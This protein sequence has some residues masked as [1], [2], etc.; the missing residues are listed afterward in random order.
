MKPLSQTQIKDRGFLKSF[1]GT[2]IYYELR[3][4]GEPVIFTYGIACMLNDFIYQARHLSQ[5]YQTCLYDLRGHHYSA[6]P[7]KRSNLSLVALAKDVKAL[8]D[9]MGGKKVHL[10]SHCFGSHVA[11]KT[12][13][14]YPEI[15]KTM[16]FF[17]GYSKNII[18]NMFHSR[19]M[20]IVY[21]EI[22]KCY[23][24]LPATI[25]SLKD[26]ALATP[27]LPLSGL[28]LIGGFNMTKTA[29]KDVEVYTQGLIN[30]DFSV[31]FKLFNESIKTNFEP[32][33]CN[34]K[35]PTLFVAGGKDTITPIQH[36]KKMSQKVPDSQWYPFLNGSHCPQLDYP[37]KCNEIL[38]RFF[39][40]F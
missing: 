4:E 20:S 34:I 1:D 26:L 2:P 40:D 38:E 10:V 11:F 39:S 31:F 29:V 9:M 33:L 16:S 15:V 22:Y 14:L 17:S 23:K 18:K 7:K 32:S 36:Q 19:F 8:S 24:H 35:V 37:K 27:L 13:E 30:L 28:A 5:K 21:P 3:G 12:Y 6:M 25:T